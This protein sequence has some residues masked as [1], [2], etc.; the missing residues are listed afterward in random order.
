MSAT[1]NIELVRRFVE[2]AQTRHNLAAVDEYMSADFVDHS[3]PAGLPP[4]RDGVKMQFS[5]F[6]NALPDL[7]A[8]IHDQ[9]ADDDKVVTRKTLRGTHQ[10]DLMGIPPTGKAIDIEV[11]DVLRVRDGKITD[12][13]NLVDRLGL[14]Q[15]LGV[16][17]A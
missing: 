8:I 9:V 11:I 1:D 15:Q 6:F 10:G 12:H 5:M 4:T 14:M 3:V 13:W 16:I 2:E 17:P 7:R